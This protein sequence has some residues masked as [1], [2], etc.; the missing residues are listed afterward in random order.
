MLPLL[1]PGDRIFVD[2]SDKA[3]SNLHDGDVI[4]LRHNDGAVVK[5]I[6]AMQGETIYGDHRKVFRDGKQLE[7]P[8]LAPAT[9]EEIEVLATFSPR[10]IGA[11][12][13]FVMG[14]NR[15]ISADSRLDE[16]GTVHLTDVV[17]KYMWTYWHGKT[18][19]KSPN[20]R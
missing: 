8:Y 17:G 4:V 12:E 18:A 2:E 14:D 7:E 1:G 13:V 15:D 6:L 19:A 16:Y 10:K 11:G 20:E 3:R 5:R 9:G